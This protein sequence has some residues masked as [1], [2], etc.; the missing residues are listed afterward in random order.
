MSNGE[1]AMNYTDTGTRIAVAGLI[2]CLVL[3]YYTVQTEN[4]TYE[5][6]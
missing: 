3:W 5:I 2:I 4:S 1:I 6:Y